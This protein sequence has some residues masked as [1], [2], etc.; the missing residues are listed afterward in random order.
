MARLDFRDF[1]YLEKPETI[2]C[3]ILDPRGRICCHMWSLLLYKINKGITC[4]IMFRKPQPYQTIPWQ[5]YSQPLDDSTD[6]GMRNTLTW[7]FISSRDA[8]KM[9]SYHPRISTRTIPPTD[10]LS[11]YERIN[12]NY[13]VSRLASSQ[14]DLG[15]AFHCRRR[16]DTP[17]NNP[18]AEIM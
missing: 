13:S 5:H 11:L 16:G 15:S 12:S 1:V 4:R 8:Q 6:S 2:K 17:R 3:G 10:S 7:N 9:K 18:V 14:N